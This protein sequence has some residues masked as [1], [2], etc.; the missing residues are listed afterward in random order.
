MAHCVTSE[1]VRISGSVPFVGSAAPIRWERI[2][3][4]IAHDS[5]G[6]CDCDCRVR[7]STSVVAALRFAVPPQTSLPA[8]SLAPAV[9]VMAV[10]SPSVM[11]R[12]LPY[13]KMRV[14]ECNAHRLPGPMFYD[15][16]ESIVVPHHSAS[17]AIMVPVADPNQPPWLLSPAEGD[18]IPVIGFS[19]V[20]DAWIW[21]RLECTSCCEDTC[22]T[23][24][25][26]G[27]APY[28][29]PVPPG[30]REVYFAGPSEAPDLSVVW[31]PIG[32]ASTAE[33]AAAPGTAAPPLEMRVVPAAYSATVG[34]TSPGP[35]SAAWKVCR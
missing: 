14:G 3:R 25:D 22:G 33:N 30:A 2:T 35:V 16:G 12:S 28:V 23:L 5:L 29:F 24:T 20:Y 6:P 1:L 7:V 4:R 9:D 11:V 32:T 21:Y 18:P 31:S 8:L 27:V 13:V 17:L 15:I 19:A 34:S 10:P 26:S